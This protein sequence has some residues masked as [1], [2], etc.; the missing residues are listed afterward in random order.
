MTNV[1]RKC[2]L[3]SQGAWRHL[4]CLCKALNQWNNKKMEIIYCL[5]MTI[6][7]MS[8]YLS[9][10]S[11][12]DLS[13]FLSKFIVPFTWHLYLVSSIPSV[14]EFAAVRIIVMYIYF[15]S[16]LSKQAN[17]T[18]SSHPLILLFF[19]CYKNTRRKL[20]TSK[21]LDRISLESYRI[22]SIEKLYIYIYWFGGY[23]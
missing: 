17:K 15:W 5:T 2:E 7:W 8:D 21:I 22:D 16:H 19:V 10:I 6:V 14:W 18:W 3:M 1:I 4:R 13:Y 12:N 23:W 11:S 9:L 20:F